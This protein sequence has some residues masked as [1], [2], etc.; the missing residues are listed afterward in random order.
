MIEI[1]NL[2][3]SFGKTFILNIPS[4]GLS[5]KGLICLMGENGSGKSTFFKILLDLILPVS[6]SVKINGSNI[7]ENE[8]WKN[9]VTA[10]LG[11]DFLIDYLTPIEYFTLVGNL[12]GVSKKQ[13]LQKLALIENDFL[14]PDLHQKLIRDLSLGNKNKVGIISCFLF[15]S[16][17][18]IL[19]EPFSSLDF[20]SKVALRRMF[21]NSPD[22]LILF[23]HH[24]ID[25]IL[26]DCNTIL[27]LNNGMIKYTI[28]GETSKRK[29]V[30]D[31]LS[32]KPI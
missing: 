24:E 29:A 21:L 4:L 30:M 26:D 25:E 9:E 2:T 22:K 14:K 19:D 23:S 11:L 7:H 18:I 16:K 27:F 15:D 1:K 17:I 10:Y 20:K 5:D 32:A 31:Y 12:K 3:K 13:T 8:Q 6:G 28:E